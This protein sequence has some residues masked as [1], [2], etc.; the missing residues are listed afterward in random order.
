MLVYLE[1]TTGTFT[2]ENYYQYRLLDGESRNTTSGA[3]P[4][5]NANWT[6]LAAT[7]AVPSM[8]QV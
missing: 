3:M 5:A 1:N 4:N 8:S 6:R 7:L 2:G